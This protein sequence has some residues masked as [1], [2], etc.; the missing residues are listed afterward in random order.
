MI[1]CSLAHLT[2]P[3]LFYSLFFSRMNNFVSGIAYDRGKT[4]ALILLN[5]DERLA[6]KT[7]V[8]VL[9]RIS[10]GYNEIH[11]K[12]RQRTEISN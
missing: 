1:L 8:N 5:E 4:K 3:V 9:A 7:E 10:I 6:L 12:I 2:S 11:R